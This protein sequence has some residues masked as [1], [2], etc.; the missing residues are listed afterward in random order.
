MRDAFEE[1]LQDNTVTPVFDQV[2]FRIDFPAWLYTLTD[3]D[4]RVI[5]DMM[6]GERTIDV[7]DNHGL[8]AGR[9]SQLRRERS[10]VRRSRGRPRRST[11]HSQSREGRR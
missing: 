10:A 11:R 5:E 6:Q 7:A 2:Q 9:V 3:H 8:T 1:R 4:R